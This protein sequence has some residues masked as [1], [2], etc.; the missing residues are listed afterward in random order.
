MSLKAEYEMSQNYPPCAYE[1]FGISHTYR[2]VNDAD[3][4]EFTDRCIKENAVVQ[5]ISNYGQYGY[6]PIKL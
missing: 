5:F 3:I 4:K 1:Q 2:L 6:R